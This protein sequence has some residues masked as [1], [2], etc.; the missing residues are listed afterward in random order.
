MDCP[1]THE[2]IG[3]YRQP[4]EIDPNT[5][6][7]EHVIIDIGEEVQCFVDETDN[8]RDFEYAFDELFNEILMYLADNRMVA[9]GLKALGEE[10]AFI[11]SSDN[12]FEDGA[13]MTAATIRLAEA[14]HKK[15]TLLGLYTKEG[16]MPYENVRWLDL[17]TPVLNRF[18][19]KH[20]L[21]GGSVRGKWQ[22]LVL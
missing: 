12:G 2:V 3:R 19:P 14:L 5:C 1:K 16:L 18:K 9:E 6:V 4:T 15:F 10:I 13:M 20:A 21:H 22:H 11:H 7:P 8:M 17:N